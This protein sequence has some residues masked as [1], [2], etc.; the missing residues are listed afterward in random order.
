MPETQIQIMGQVGSGKSLGAA[1][2]T[3]AE[4]ITRKDAVIWAIDIT[5][6]R[7]TLGPVEGSL[8]RLA[9]TPAEAISV[10]RDAQ[11]LIKTRTDYLAA[12]GL[13]KWQKDCGI[14]YLIIWIEE[15]PEVMEALAASG[16]DGEDLWI[17]SVKAARSAGITF[18]WSLQRADYTQIPTITRGQA[19]KWCFGVADSH[20]ASFGLSEIQGN[21]GCAP[22]RWG[23]R[24]P[25]MCYLDAP[26]IEADQ[27]P[28]PLRTWYWGPDDKTIKAHAEKFP[29]SA[30][31]PRLDGKGIWSSETPG[32]PA[33]VTEPEDDEPETPVDQ[34]YD[35]R[36]EELD[37]E[38]EPLDGDFELSH[39]EPEGERPG[40]EEARAKLREWLVERAGQSVRNADLSEVRDA[41]GYS[42]RWSNKVLSEFESAG[43]V[44]RDDEASTSQGGIVWTVTAD[45]AILES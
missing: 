31:P 4:L 30:R 3:L 2:S 24:Q 42:R 16:D 22:E 14:D 41:M 13:G 32:L 20:E 26:S 33:A 7:Q 10:L 40:P 6:G 17:K 5:K 35:M 29:A 19:I 45:P 8:H 15:V 21:S 28:V 44:A 23:Q 36:D 1:W 37:T 39:P 25:G 34:E 12:K 27:I 9:T 38:L 43:L 18:A 11:G